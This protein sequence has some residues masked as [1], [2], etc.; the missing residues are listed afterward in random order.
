V[1]KLA[2]DREEREEVRDWTRWCREACDFV[3]EERAEERREKLV[4]VMEV[5]KIACVEN[6]IYSVPKLA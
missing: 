5:V 3:I 1:E 4:M 6:C 2:A